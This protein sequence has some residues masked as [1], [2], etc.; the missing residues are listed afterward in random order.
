MKHG[1]ATYQA[2][3]GEALHASGPNAAAQEKAARQVPL[4]QGFWSLLGFLG[5]GQV[6]GDSIDHPAAV[7]DTFRPAR[8]AD[9]RKT[10][11]PDAPAAS[12]TQTLSA[13]SAGPVAQQPAPSAPPLPNSLHSMYNGSSADQSLLTYPS[14]S[15]TQQAEPRMH[16]SLPPA[17]P[18]QS[19]RDSMPEYCECP[20]SRDAVTALGN[21]P[22]HAQ[23]QQQTD[24]PGAVAWA[25]S[26]ASGALQ[27]AAA[28]S[29]AA[30]TAL[31]GSLP[32]P[33]R[34][35][36]EAGAIGPG[37]AEGQSGLQRQS[38]R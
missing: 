14:L 9:G 33:R 4:L 29:G 32:W 18:T 5:S 28:T 16:G 7:R 23:P 37:A 24:Q 20:S 12:E 35:Q 38:G 6:T 25:L 19:F 34:C 1:R 36:P 26:N 27:G 30:L 13:S 31:L 21:S 22:S 17:P 2:P 3:A 11:H 15:P 10:S 8:I